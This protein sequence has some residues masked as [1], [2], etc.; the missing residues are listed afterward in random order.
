MFRVCGM[1]PSSAAITKMTG[2]NPGGAGDH[3]LDEILMPRTST[4]PTSSLPRAT[5]RTQLNGHASLFFSLSPI[6]FASVKFKTRAV[7]AVIN[8]AGSAKRLYFL[9]HV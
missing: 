8:M 1:M 6:R 5:G 2:I 3:R 4:M 9:I 7:F